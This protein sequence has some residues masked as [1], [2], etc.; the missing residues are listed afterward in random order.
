MAIIQGLLALVSRS[1]GRITS[2]MF[3]WAVVALFGQ[4]SGQEKVVL[5]G[6][7]AAAAAWPI[8]LL[9]IAVPKV[10]AFVLAFV[11]LPDWV[12]AWTVRVGWIVLA[13]AV[14][15][16]IGITMAKRRPAAADRESALTRILRGFPITV[17]I[18][19]AF[20]LIFVTVP[21]LRVVSIMRRR[22]DRQVP[23][24]TDAGSYD[25]VAAIVARTLNDHGFTVHE[26][27]PG[28]WMT[29]PSGILLRLGGAAFR[30]YVPQRL[31][32]LRGPRLEVALYPN[33]VLL[34]GNEQDAGWAHG[35]V[36]EALTDAPA[37]QTFDPG[38]QAIEHQIRRVWRVYRANPAAHARSTA[39]LGRLA[40]I[41]HE[42]RR[43][44]VPYDEWQIVYRQALQLGR[45]LE[46]QGQLLETTS[47]EAAGGVVGSGKERLMATLHNGTSAQALSNR[48]LIGEITAKAMQLAKKELE[49]A[50]VEIGADMKA[51]LAMA[52]ALGVSLAAALT[53][54]NLLLV[55]GVFAL[56]TI[57]PGW[58]A[59]LIVGGS[60]LAIAVLMGY[61]GWRHHVRSPLALTRQMLKEDVQWVKERVA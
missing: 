13:A 44:P 36:V 14:P 8:L 41:A 33:S 3:G 17:G 30:A 52:K 1:L 51:E 9:G 56:A 45:T 24:V 55:A 25:E 21:A 7:V 46:G 47:S 42:I 39:L 29:A 31:A 50:R 19:A 12:P 60:M 20:I 28:W 22:I 16:A 58:L 34:R 27:T 61:L 57:I 26:A 38:A 48:A 18:A 59:G 11:P 53:G 4:T 6:L 35:V 2:T 23:L 49:L 32:Y 15:V 54:M 37:Y 5:S 40:D 10:S 43:L